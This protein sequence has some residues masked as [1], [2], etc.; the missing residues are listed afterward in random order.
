MVGGRS[1]ESSKKGVHRFHIRI[2]RDEAQHWLVVGVITRAYQG[3]NSRYNGFVGGDAA[4]GY[5]WACGDGSNIKRCT[6]WGPP[7]TQAGTQWGR[8]TYN[9]GDVVTLVL[10]MNKKTLDFELNGEKASQDGNPCFTGLPDE[11]CPA[12][13]TYDIGDGYTIVSSAKPKKKK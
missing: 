12:V 2:D 11:V 9:T 4:T 5:G 13:S 3:Y 10:D 1:G 6:K 7:P 8:Q